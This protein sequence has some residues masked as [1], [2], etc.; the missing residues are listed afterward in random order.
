MPRRRSINNAWICS[1][2]SGRSSLTVC[3]NDTQIDIKVIVDNFVPHAAHLDPRQFRVS[4]DELR[5]LLV[6]PVCCLT[7]DFDGPNYRGLG[8]TI[9]S[10]R[11]HVISI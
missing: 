6:N 10:E 4:A 11:R 3:Q 5:R 7:D 8:L 9:L 2:N 1:R